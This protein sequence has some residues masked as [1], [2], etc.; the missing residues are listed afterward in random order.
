MQRRAGHVVVGVKRDRLAGTEGGRRTVRSKGR[1][2]ENEVGV[3]STFS[4]IASDISS[5]DPDLD[6]AV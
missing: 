3:V 6:L 5:T 2:G 4:R 1:G